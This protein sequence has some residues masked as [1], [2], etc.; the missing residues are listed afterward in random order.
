MPDVTI[1]IPNLNGAPV[2]GACLG[3]LGSAA[4][5]RC[6]AAVVVDNASHDSSVEL[7]RARFPAVKVLENRENLGFAAACNQGGQ[8]LDSRYVLLLNSDVVLPSGS[9]EAMIRF[10]DAH[11][12]VGALTPRMCW[13]DG[14]IQGPRLGLSSLFRKG[15]VP[16]GWAPGTCLLLRR[17]ALDAVGWLDESFFFYNEDIDL[18]WRLRKGGWKI[19]CLPELRVVHQEGAATRSDSAV[20]ARAMA[21][22]Y[23]GSVLLTRKHFPWATRMVRWLLARE[24]DYHAWRLPLMRRLGRELNDRD[25]ALGRCLSQARAALDST[26]G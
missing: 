1:V 2:L 4:A 15:A 6:W 7:V 10:A 20:R 25:E 5:D 14:R 11:P 22:G 24:L 17:S 3:S 8:P 21:E 16:M 9:L 18:S 13:P 23:R 26:H 19:V 12:D